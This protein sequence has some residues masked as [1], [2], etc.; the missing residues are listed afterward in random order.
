MRP[1]RQRREAGW[2]LFDAPVAGRPR[3]T[4]TCDW[5]LLERNAQLAG[6][7]KFARIPGATGLRL[8]AELPLETFPRKAPA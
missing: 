4:D 7:V 8:R 6:G 2:I 3:A 1:P 5:P